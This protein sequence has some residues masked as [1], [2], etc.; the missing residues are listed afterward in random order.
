MRSLRKHNRTC[1]CRNPLAKGNKPEYSIHW[2]NKL[3]N[4]CL[5]SFLRNV[6]EDGMT[7]LY[8]SALIHRLVTPVM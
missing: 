7:P 6:L 3:S 8:F 4:K 2:F 1:L 5:F